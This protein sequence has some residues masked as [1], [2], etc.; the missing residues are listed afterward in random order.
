MA[1]RIARYISDAN[2]IISLEL[3]EALLT[4][5]GLFSNY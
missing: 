1:D 4:L 2:R 3:G 5:S